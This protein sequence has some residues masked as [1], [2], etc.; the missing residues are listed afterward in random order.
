ME[1]V[2]ILGIHQPVSRVCLGTMTFGSQ[3]NEETAASMLSVALER[4]IN[5]VDT[6]N[7]YNKGASE[8][9]TGRLLKGRRE[10]VVLATKVGIAMGTE[11]L[12]QGLSRKT[13]MYQVE[14]SLRRLQTDYVDIYYLHAPD[15]KT[16]IEE[17]LSAVTD[18]HRQ[19][20]IRALGVSNYAAWQVVQMRWLAE[21]KK[22]VPVAIA[23]P[24]YNLLARRLDAEFIPMAK[25]IGIATAVYNPLAGG[26]LTGKHT[27]ASAAP[28]TGTRFD[29]NA[30]YQSR[31]WL[32]ENFDAVSR[33]AAAAQE[34]Q[35]SL[36]SLSLNWLLKHSPADCV[37]LGASS[38]EQFEGNL[39]TLNE[40]PLQAKTLE[41][42]EDVARSLQGVAPTYIR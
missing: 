5:F 41:V 29:K 24:M 35:R 21:T 16:P 15:H 40:P 17:S 2:T 19:G 11:P 1:T 37:I 4:G 26:L 3:V 27:S 18:L 12:D 10:Q 22:L 34:E 23:Q 7:V 32:P 28:P 39:N 42:C 33:L 36:V 38:L 25:Q 20:K 30:A 13:I 31:Y 8:E 14:N 9:M 6:A